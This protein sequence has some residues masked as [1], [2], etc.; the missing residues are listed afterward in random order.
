MRAKFSILRR[1]G[2]GFINCTGQSRTP[3][4]WPRRHFLGHEL[5]VAMHDHAEFH[6]QVLQNKP[7]L[8][9]VLPRFLGGLRPCPSPLGRAA[10]RRID[11]GY[12]LFAPNYFRTP[13]SHKEPC[14]FGGKGTTRPNLHHLN[15]T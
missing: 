10:L 1:G 3:F 2:E 13:F 11:M 15:F 8:S 4:I 9:F 14:I 5:F 7:A 12:G 6:R